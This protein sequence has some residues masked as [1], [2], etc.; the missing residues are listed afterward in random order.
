MSNLSNWVGSGVISE[1]CHESQGADVGGGDEFRAKMCEGHP[2]GDSKAIG[3]VGWELRLQIIW[4]RDTNSGV[5]NTQMIVEDIGTTAGSQ[6][7]RCSKNL[8]A[9]RTELSGIPSCRDRERGSLKGDRAGAKERGEKTHKHRL[10]RPRGN[11][12][13]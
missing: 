2:D 4:V 6:A 5:T 11:G 1:T 10:Q 3:Y 7:S 8:K 12:I 9:H 13:L